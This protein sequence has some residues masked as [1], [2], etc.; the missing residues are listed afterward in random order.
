MKVTGG[1]GFAIV[2]LMVLYSTLSQKTEAMFFWLLVSVVA[3]I[4]NPQLIPKGGGFSLMQRGL[5]VFLGFVMAV[6]V[7]A[8]P[9][10]SVIRPYT[11]MIFYVLFMIMSSAQGWNPKI[12]FLKLLLF[13]LIYF[14]YVGMSNQV[15]INP[16]VSSRRIRSVMLSMATLFIC[17]SMM[18]LP[19]PGISQMQAV[20]YGLESID[21]SQYSSLFMGMTSHSQCLGPVVSVLSVILLGDLLFSIKKADPLYMFMLCCCPYLIYLTSSRTGMGAYILGQMFVLWV[22]M[23]ARGQGR[24]WKSRVMTFVMTVLTS[25]LVVSAFIPS[26]QERA[27][28]FLLKSSYGDGQKVTA[29][30]VTSTRKGKI[31]EALHNFKKSPLIG[32]GFQVVAEMKKQK[33]EGLSI[34]SAPIEKGVWV[35]AVLEEGGVI[36]WVIFVVFLL[37]CIVKSLKCRAYIGASCLFVCMMTN[38]GE[39]TFFSMSYSGGFMWAMVFVGLALDIRKMKDENEAMQR[40]MM[41]R[42]MEMEMMQAEGEPPFAG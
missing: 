12:S 32:N 16:Q 13:T 37:V 26:V 30:A 35:T 25:L 15:G 6:R 18:L 4:V 36:G 17:G 40:E 8:Y 41:Q 7:M 20:T 5:M 21:L 39:F 38:L 42:Q 34:F 19:F 23:N 3:I 27:A 9:L 29:E 14:A 1:A 11:G 10:H 24:R 28:A 22:F 2:V 33:T 31:Y